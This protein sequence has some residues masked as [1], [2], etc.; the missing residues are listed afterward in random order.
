MENTGES[1]DIANN[2]MDTITNEFNQRILGAVNK[3]IEGLREIAKQESRD[4][5]EKALQGS[6]ESRTRAN[7]DA[8]KILRVANL[9]AE[10]IIKDAEKQRDSM[11]AESKNGVE[12]IINVINDINENLSCFVN[13]AKQMK[14][15]STIRKNE[16]RVDEKPI[17]DSKSAQVLTLKEYI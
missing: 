16:E 3:E 5:I 17:N 10:Q 9:R 4:I 11:I 8:A 12:R 7:E 6:E 1:P 15:E 14:L 2:L 13:D